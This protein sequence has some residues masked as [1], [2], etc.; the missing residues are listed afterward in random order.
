MDVNW[1]A[2]RLTNAEYIDTFEEF[3][4]NTD[5][6]DKATEIVTNY[7]NNLDQRENLNV[8]L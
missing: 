6:Y 8:N 2:K 1:T 4:K 5:Q 3:V 7:V